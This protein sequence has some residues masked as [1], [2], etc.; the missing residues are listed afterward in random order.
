MVEQIIRPKT[1]LNEHLKYLDNLR[2]TGL[3]NMFGAG[4]YLEDQ[5]DLSKADAKIVLIYWMKTFRGEE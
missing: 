4:I 2:K 1:V 5:F 3:T